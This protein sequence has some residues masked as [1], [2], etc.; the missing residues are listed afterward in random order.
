MKRFV[1]LIVTLLVLMLLW[2][3]GWV[4]VAEMAKAGV[5]SLADADGV[6]NPRLTCDGLG[7]GGFPFGLD[8]TCTKARIASQDMRVDLAGFEA[9]WSLGQPT[10]LALA[11]QGPAEL[12]DAFTG[13][14]QSLAFT[15]ARASAQLEGLRIGRVSLHLAEVTLS[16]MLFGSLLAKVGSVEAD[17]VD[18]PEQ[19][20]AQNHLS[21]LAGYLTLDGI[22]LPGAGI[23]D[24][25]TSLEA[26]VDGLPDD[27]RGFAGPDLVARWRAAGGKLKLVSFK[28]DDA[29]SSFDSSGEV[30]LDANA[31]LEGQVT[32]SSNNIVE[33]TGNLV[34]P[35]WKPLILG[36]Q[37]AD[38]SYSQT[39]NIR[40][41]TVF[42]GIIPIGEIPPLY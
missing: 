22:D 6:A 20:D 29:Q 18:I 2:C 35:E 40:G 30:S 5:R 32:V 9:H 23:L 27:I 24:G 38:G 7:V 12:A 26:E 17:L 10:R 39:L 36:A 19:H 11:A 42:S 31:R 33:R 25:R 3:I 28:G 21:A 16:D 13:S 37:A 4:V 1:Y 34:P 14:R 15:D 8:L 41:G